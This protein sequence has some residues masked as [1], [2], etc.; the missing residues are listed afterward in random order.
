MQTEL[1]AHEKHQT[2]KEVEQPQED[3]KM[4]D[5]RQICKIRKME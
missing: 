3:L 1:Y 2:W 4:V 5:T